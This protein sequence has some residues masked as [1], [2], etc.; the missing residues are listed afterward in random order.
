MIEIFQ[1]GGTLF[2]SLI[3]IAQIVMFLGIVLDLSGKKGRHL[4]REAGMLALAIGVLGQLIG[5][6][7]AFKAIEAMGGVSAAML[8]GGLKV[9]SVTT[10]YGLIGFII[11][12]L[13][14]LIGTK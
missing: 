1:M 12:R 8:A 6:F 9:S 7:D 4:V 11:S 2:M 5:L 10:I 13:Y 3:S 14:L